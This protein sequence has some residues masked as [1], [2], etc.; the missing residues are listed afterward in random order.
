M[1]HHSTPIHFLDINEGV[2]YNKDAEFLFTHYAHK[3]NVTDKGEEIVF[4]D[5]DN[6]KIMDWRGWTQIEKIEKSINENWYQ[7]MPIV[8]PEGLYNHQKFSPIEVSSDTLIP[9]YDP[10]KFI[11]G[12]HGEVKF[13]YKLK[14]V[15]QLSST[16]Q[17]RFLKL[18]DIYG[19]NHRFSSVTLYP[20]NSTIIGY[21]I[22]TKSEF[23][24]AGVYHLY[25]SDIVSENIFYK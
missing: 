20:T 24:N 14:K 19:N 2:D 4:T 12:F 21:K 13:E 11:R 15:D 10:H 18:I 17:L 9:V 22:Y 23:F 25:A 5:N 3:I 16:D 7:L 1:I 6:V 8:I